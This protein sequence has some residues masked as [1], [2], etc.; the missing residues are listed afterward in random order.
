M[1]HVY[2]YNRAKSTKFIYEPT[3]YLVSCDNVEVVAYLAHSYGIIIGQ[4]VLFLCLVT[5]DEDSN[6]INFELKTLNLYG[7]P[8]KA[9]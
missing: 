4:F 6:I 7:A 8:Y 1:V 9:K 3:Y 5:Q 2:F